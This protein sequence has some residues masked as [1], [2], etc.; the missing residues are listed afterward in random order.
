[1]DARVCSM[2]FATPATDN[3]DRWTCPALLGNWNK[4]FPFA[5]EVV[6]PV[7]VGSRDVEDVVLPMTT[8]LILKLFVP[9]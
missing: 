4:I 1:M 7:A 9:A 8:P 5:S 2:Q 6:V 3:A